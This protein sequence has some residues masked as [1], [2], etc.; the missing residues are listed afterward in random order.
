[1]LKSH[2]ITRCCGA[3]DIGGD[4]LR[5]KRRSLR[6]GKYKRPNRPELGEWDHPNWTACQEAQHTFFVSCFQ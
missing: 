5:R 3:R 4:G 2:E 1:M 6:Q